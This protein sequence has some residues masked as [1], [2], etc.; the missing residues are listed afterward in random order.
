LS[1][2][3]KQL[4]SIWRA[5]RASA[6]IAIVLPVAA[7]AG[8]TKQ[9]LERVGTSHPQPNARLPMSVTLQ[10]GKSQFRTVA[11]WLDK[12]PGVWIVAD[13]TCQTLC[14]PVLR[15]AADALTGSGLEPGRDFNLLVLGLDPKDGAAEGTAMKRAQ[16]GTEGPLA[17]HT[18]MLRGTDESTRQ[19]AE[20]LGFRAAYDAEHD[21]FAHPAAVFVI[22]ADGHVSRIF[23]G[24]SV[25]PASMR[26]ALVEAGEG[27]IGT[28]ADHVRLLCYGFD[29]TRGTYNLI[30]S[31]ALAI[32]GGTT[33]AV[34]AL[35]LG[36]MFQHERA[37]RR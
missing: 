26:L 17:A 22:T 14:S 31:H 25:E 20:S 5:I 2:F 35:F 24:L 27:R 10:D 12:K 3:T 23:S 11:A 21:Q 30:I 7:Y 37:S 15:T 16:I 36:L 1:H 32:G 19:I 33:I 29:P 8:V 34:I 13:F 9:D 4:A 18:V 28:L 6:L